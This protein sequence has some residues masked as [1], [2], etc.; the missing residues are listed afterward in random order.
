MALVVPAQL[1]A[2]PVP[3]CKYQLNEASCTA[4]DPY[5]AI[6]PWAV[7]PPLPPRD[8]NPQYQGNPDRAPTRLSG[9]MADRT[10]TGKLTLIGNAE[11]QRGNQRLRAQ[12]IS[13]DDQQG[14]VEAWGEIQYDDVDLSLV[15]DH[16]RMWINEDRG[17]FFNASYTL[18]D[19]H[20]RG[21]SAI[22][23][24]LEPGV[25]EYNRATYTTCAIND[26]FWSLRGSKVTLDENTGVGVARNARLHVK[27]VPVLYTPYVTFPIDDRRKTGFLAPSFG[28]SDSSGLELT[29]PYYLNLAPNYDATLTAR[30]LQDRG[31]QLN[32]EFRYL[33]PW[34]RDAS[35]LNLEYLSDDDKT[36]TNRSRF[37]YQDHSRFSQ[38]LTTNIDYDRVSDKSYL[39]DLNDNLGLSSKSFLQRTGEVNY[40]TNWWSA[41]ARVDD[42]QTVDPDVKRKNRPYQ[43]LPRLT[44]DFHPRP[45]SLGLAL[46]AP[47]EFVRFDHD[48]K[49]TGDRVDLWPTISLPINRTAYEMTPTAGIRYTTYDLSDQDPSDPGSPSR[50][51]P[52]FSLDNTVF[53][54]RDVNIGPGNYI[55]T[56]EPRLYYLYVKDS[57]QDDIPIF[58][59]ST[60]TFTY[61]EL[62]VENRFSGA[63]RMGDANQVTLALTSQL[64][65]PDSG[66][67]LVKASIGGIRYF[68]DRKVQLK[69]D[70]PIET[71]D[72]S[73]VAGDLSVAISKAWSG[74]ADLVWDP[75]DSSTERLNARVQYNPGFRKIANLSYRY[76]R[77]ENLNNNQNQANTQNQIDASVLWP[78]TPNWQ[79]LGRWYYDLDAS[80][81]LERTV[82][83]EY[84]NCC[85]GI[86][87][88][89]REFIKDESETNQAVLFQ[90]V[91]KGL[92]HFGNDI[93]SELQNGILGYTERPED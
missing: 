74:R 40:D 25:T 44:F 54:E 50:T 7:C 63:D 32:T 21:T 72:W 13:Y 69:P 64:T 90:F 86:R 87:M 59:S 82:G 20:A 8:Y 93:E 52:M 29:V 37:T 2:E 79:I 78:L 17:E 70:T 81:I 45:R 5:A 12:H 9:E 91:F 47:T 49:V 60:R 30:H 36:G 31:L 53:F 27:D 4:V 16:G 71:R 92:A 68:R 22:S 66:A 3:D 23:Y 10:N 73:D 88:V 61:N 42:Y 57:N 18:Y 80:Q 34:S 56:L 48:E 14:L 35:F 46:E 39:Q 24:L 76:L 75:Y 43:R 26:N 6:S 77:K 51:T 38:H 62:F 83:I 58:D 65:S 85:W 89:A 19:R 28:S 33:T 84:D 41:A 15:A 11:A 67:R 1:R 55:Q